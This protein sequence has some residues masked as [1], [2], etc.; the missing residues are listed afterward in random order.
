MK[1]RMGEQAGV[2]I[3]VSVTEDGRPRCPQDGEPM[4]LVGPNQ[5][6]CPIGKAISD[7]LA[8]ALARAFGADAGPD[9][10]YLRDT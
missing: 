5:W 10:D 4:E 3:P 6:Q 8:Q 7:A 9:S 1:E 2:L